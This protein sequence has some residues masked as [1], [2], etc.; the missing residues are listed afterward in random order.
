[1]GERDE[2]NRTDF[3]L[4]RDHRTFENR[5]GSTHPGAEHGTMGGSLMLGMVP[6]MLD[7]LR[8][9][10]S[11]DGKDTEH[12]EDRQK[13]EEGVVHQKTTQYDLIKS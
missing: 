3:G 11:S 4:K 12:Q 5:P 9:S 8:L 13:F 2:S 7:Q 10:Q 6:G 1:M